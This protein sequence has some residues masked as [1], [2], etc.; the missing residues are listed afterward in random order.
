MLKVIIADDEEH[1]CRLIRALV[2]WDALQMEIVG[3][4][5]NGIEA[6]ELAAEL[7]PDIMITDIRMPGCDGLE[8]IQRVKESNP[9][10]EIVIISG[11]AHFSYAQTAIKYGVGDYLLKPI[12]KNE[13]IQ[14][15][16]KLS[17]KI[18][19]RNHVEN[20]MKLLL[21]NKENYKKRAR[22][23]LITELMDQEETPLTLKCLEEEYHFCAKPGFFQGICLK[24]DYDAEVINENAGKIVFEKAM[25]LIQGNL[26]ALCFDFMMNIKADTAYGII[27][28][29]AKV[30]DDIRRNLRDCLNQL[31]VQ[32]SMLGPVDFTIALG[33]PVRDVKQLSGSLKEG[34]KVMQERILVGP[35][36]LLEKIPKQEGIHDKKLLEKYSRMVLHAVEVLSEDEGEDAIAML[37]DFVQQK[38]NIRGFEIFDLVIS[39]GSLFLMQT[40]YKKDMESFRQECSRCAT[41]A[42]LFKCLSKL[43]GSIIRELYKERQDEKQRPIRIAKRYIQS[44]YSEQITLEEVSDAVGLS[45]S[46]FSTL[47][48][49]E[50][51]EGF[52]KYLIYVRMEQ[53][54]ILLRETNLSVADICRQVGYNDLKHFTHTFEKAT[55]LRPGTY[56]KLYG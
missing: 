31:T 37:Q 27:H 36:H 13:L 12:N 48:K 1:I 35:G 2:D 7:Q 39:A 46:Y 5:S 38:K 42:D 56:R 41:A 10:L 43:Q 14:T 20:D 23:N 8:L 18:M 54:R 6:S 44:H 11:Y 3:T 30:Q 28:Y 17:E 50:T 49:K 40:E 52:A 4:A 25:D 24:M 53:A 22:S 9:Q 33:M 21:E 19:T 16:Q 29:P 15:L 26:K 45:V 51:G 34:L 32:K 55:G 47:F